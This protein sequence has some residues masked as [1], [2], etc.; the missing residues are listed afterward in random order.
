VPVSTQSRNQFRLI[1]MLTGILPSSVH[2]ALKQ[3]A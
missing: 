2:A 3:I 1:F